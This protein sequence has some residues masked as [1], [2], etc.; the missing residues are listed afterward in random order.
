MGGN[1]YQEHRDGQR[2]KTGFQEFLEDILRAEAELCKRMRRLGG[3]RG[4]IFV[5]PDSLPNIH[6][7]VSSNNL[8]AI[9]IP[10]RLHAS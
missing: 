6:N 7:D 1:F 5:H 2:E 3:D 8:S 9:L 4:G 10:A